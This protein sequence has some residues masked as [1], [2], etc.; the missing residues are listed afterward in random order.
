MPDVGGGF[1]GIYSEFMWITPLS[2][3][4]PVPAPE[5][6]PLALLGLAT[7]AYVVKRAR[8]AWKDSIPRG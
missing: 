5:P 8:A 7:V 3:G 1:E 2:P 6:T 4:A